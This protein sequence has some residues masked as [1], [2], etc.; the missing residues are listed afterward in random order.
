[1]QDV[2]DT[3]VEQQDAPFLVAMTGDSEGVT[4][5]GTSGSA[6]DGSAATLDTA[7]RIFSMTKAVGATAAMILIERGELSFDTPV[8][9]VIPAFDDLQV[10]QS[11]EGGDVSLVDARATATVRHL[12]THTSGLV[13]EYWDA[14]MA[15]YLEATGATPVLSGTKE[16]LRYPLAFQPGA[17]WGYGIGIDWLGQ[18]VEAVDGRRIDEFCQVEIFDPLAMADTSFEPNQLV[19]RMAEVKM[20]GED[21]SFGPYEI[22]PPPHPEVYGMGHALYSTAPDYLRFLRMFLRGG[23]LDGNRVLSQ[24]SVE[25]MLANHIGDLRVTPMPSQAPPLSA[26]VTLFPDT[27]KTHSFGFVRVEEDVPGMRSA[28]SQGW[29]GVLN[30]HYWFDPAAD[31]A[32]VIMT[33]SLPFADPRFMATYEAFEKAV[34]AA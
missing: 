20:R 33:Q 8:A 25:Q 28:G 2:L 7:F 27:P 31:L 18:V 11:I 29:A 9:D 14:T 5:S 1:M 21:G 23:E 30:S 6:R 15:A 17:R 26:D 16:G 34:Y 19:D 13:Y 12:A 10:I 24:Q 22:A 3:A 32:A 4:W